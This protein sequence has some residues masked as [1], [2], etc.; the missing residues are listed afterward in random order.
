MYIFEAET[1]TDL[2]SNKRNVIQ[3]A[4]PS[5]VQNNYIPQ[6]HTTTTYKHTNNIHTPYKPK[7]NAADTFACSLA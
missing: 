3:E 2:Q 6:G 7:Q 5:A 4:T 1:I